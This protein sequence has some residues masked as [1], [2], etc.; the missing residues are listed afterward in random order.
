MRSFYSVHCKP[1]DLSH[2][3]RMHHLSPVPT[4]RF[5]RVLVLATLYPVISAIAVDAPALP[6]RANPLL[7]PSSLPYQLPPF[8]QIKNED[9]APAL[10]AGM[11]E[12]IKEVEVI[13]ANPDKPTF[14]NTIVAL[15]RSGQMLTRVNAIFSNLTS[16]HTN[17]ILQE[18]ESSVAPKLAAHNDKILLDPKLFAR[19]QAVA[20]QRDSL[21][22]D[23]ESKFVLD[24]YLKDFV[25]AGAKLSEADKTK[26]KAI[27]AE[28]ASLETAFAQNVQKE[29][30]AHAIVVDDRA[31][32]AGMSENEITAAAA[33]AKEAGKP[34]KYVLPLLN[35]TGQPPLTTL[36]NRAL[37]QRIMQASLARGSQG[38]EF[39]NRGVVSRLARLRAEH[40]VLLGQPNHAAYQLEEQ[41]ARDVSRVN[42]LLA[43]L[44]P[45]AVANARL[46]AADLQAVIDHEHGGFKLAAEDW[47]L[48]SEKVRQARYAFD[49]AEVK[50]YFEL[51]HVYL[52]GVF[53][54]AHELYGITLKERHDLPVY[55]PDVRVFE[56]FDADGSP[57]ALY[58]LDPYA[59]DSK[60]GGAWMSEYVSQSGL[61]DIKPVVANHLNIPKPPSTEPTLLTFDEVKTAFHEFGH[62]LHGMFSHVYYPRFSGTNVPRDFVE[63]P[64]QVNEMW[65]AWPEV[66]KHYAKHFKTGEPM[67]SA[68][69]DKVLAAKKFNQGYVTTEY[70]A[71][72]L[73]DQSWHQLAPSE[74]PDAEHVV[75]FEEDALKK[76][77]MDFAP[78]PP[79]YRSTY[80]SHAF[81]G[82]YSAGYYSYI[83]SEVLDADSVEWFKQNG[84]LKRANGDRFRETLLSRGGSDEALTLFKNFV[85]REPYIE[86]LLVRRGLDRAPK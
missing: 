16:A 82:G 69:L 40:A 54:V 37:R 62:A 51:N 27:N 20:D 84:G 30:N 78:V 55:Q 14:A 32:L 34:G 4:R 8:D 35:T 36:T 23:A 2:L 28:I 3:D 56:V 18:V 22:L 5:W 41:T 43:D 46:E 52:D 57:L 63:Y 79:R 64:S 25:R 1:G 86:P 39:D 73:L 29:K 66:L 80:F 17:P 44:A 71:A 13:A 67:P 47:D 59:R 65:A 85:G 15:E 60:R 72:A 49:E 21:D 70:L 58:L 24:R 9:F 10:D 7:V 33:A 75:A 11:S 45:P 81:T 68:L 38:G 74:V 76:A 61:L 53:Y 42:K 19:V 48:Y 50:P 31:E 26:L 6:P 83:W 12:Q 77:G